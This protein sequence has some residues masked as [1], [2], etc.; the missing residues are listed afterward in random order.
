MRAGRLQ[1]TLKRLDAAIGEVSAALEE[2]QA[3]RD[4]LATQIFL[5]RRSYRATGDT[6]G[7]RRHGVR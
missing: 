4:P 1:N 6:K 2:M 5:S 7:G 3:E